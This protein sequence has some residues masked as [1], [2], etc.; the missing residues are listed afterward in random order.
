M[1]KTEFE[2]HLYAARGN[3]K[4]GSRARFDGFQRKYDWHM[5]LAAEYCRKAA[6]SKTTDAD[7]QVEWRVRWEG[8]EPEKGAAI[9]NANTGE[10]IVHIGGDQE[11][12]DRISIAVD[13]HNAHLLAKA[14]K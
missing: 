1:P 11:M 10:L 13:T 7:K 2:R 8:S 4:E 14:P 12:H 9:V 5:E 6:Y 3:I